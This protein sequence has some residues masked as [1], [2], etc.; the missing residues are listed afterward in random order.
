MRKIPWRRKWQPTPVFLPGESHGQRSLVG[1]SPRGHKELDTTERLHSLTPNLLIY[2][3]PLSPFGNQL[4]GYDMLILWRFC[5]YVH[6]RCWSIVFYIWFV[7]ILLEI[8]P[9]VFIIHWFVVL[10]SCNV[11]FG[12]YIKAIPTLQNEWVRK[13]SFCFYL[14]Q[15]IVENW[16]NFFP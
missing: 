11:L 16:N 7:N 9:T 12:F 2:P 4:V 6:E 3:M 5:F 14:L 15:E 13:N 1:Y 8:F 10:F